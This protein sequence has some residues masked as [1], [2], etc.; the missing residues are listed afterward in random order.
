MLNRALKFAAT[1][2]FFLVAFVST[3]AAAGALTPEG[4]ASLWS[5]VW[6][7]FR[8]GQYIYA[9]ALALV[10]GVALARVYGQ[11][12]LPWVKTDQGGVVLSLLGALGAS[13]SVSL[14]DGAPLS[15]AIV[16]RA[17]LIAV[18][19]SGGYSMIKRLIINPYVVPL[20]ARHPRLASLFSF[21]VPLFGLDQTSPKDSQN[22]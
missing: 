18:S 19:A 15:W 2:F 3:A 17:I 1:P 13:L 14:A 8:H 10:A 7:A 11:A 9:G 16:Q 20:L 6:D 4:D 12:W 21:I 5:P 22:A